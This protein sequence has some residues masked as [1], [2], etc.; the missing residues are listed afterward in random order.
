MDVA[1][2]RICWNALPYVALVWNMNQ[3]ASLTILVVIV[4]TYVEVPTVVVGFMVWYPRGPA[5]GNMC[6]S[7]NK[8]N[9]EGGLQTHPSEKG[10]KIVS[11]NFGWIWK[12]QNNNLSDDDSSS[13]SVE[14][15]NFHRPPSGWGWTK[16]ASLDRSDDTK[17]KSWGDSRRQ[18]QQ[19]SSVRT[20]VR[21]SS[22][23]GGRKQDKNEMDHQSP[24]AR[25]LAARTD[26]AS[27]VISI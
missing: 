20:C 27:E 26:R 15:G 7:S 8:T 21:M 18:S 25:A 12:Y 2:E 1:K 9:V 23:E 13:S 17:K 5:T 24:C 11:L 16:T 14:L 10:E 22:W 4:S 3:L 6:C 19:P